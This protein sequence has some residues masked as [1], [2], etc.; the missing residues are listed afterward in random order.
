M[1]MMTSFRLANGC[2]MVG[3]A[4]MHKNLD[5]V[6][7]GGGRFLARRSLA[8]ARTTAGCV[9]TSRCL[10]GGG[11]SSSSSTPPDPPEARDVYV[12]PLSQI[13]LEHLQNTHAGWVERIGLSTGLAFRPDGTF[14]LRFPRTEDEHDGG[15]TG[16]EARPASDEEGGDNSIWTVYEPEER[17]HLLC[18]TRHGLIGRYVLQDNAKPAWHTDKRSTPERVQDA[19]DEM[20]GRLE[21]RRT[22]EGGGKA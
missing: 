14:V 6:G 4:A 17:K 12:H 10:S 7:S 19:V 3:C 2:R 15:E 13:V 8:Q 22:A 1:Q 9:I 16:E 11:G 21:E 5:V 20:I 18:V